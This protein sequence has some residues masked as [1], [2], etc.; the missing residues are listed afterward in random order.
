MTKKIITEPSRD[1]PVVGNFDVVVAGGGPAGVAAAVAAARAGARTALLEAQGCLGG[2]WTS[3][4]MPWAIDY[5]DKPG[6]MAEIDSCLRSKQVPVSGAP[7][8]SAYDLEQAK[9]RLE[10]LCLQA[11]VHLRLHTRVCSALLENRDI[12]AVATE[13]KSGREAWGGR[14]FIDSTGDGELAKH[15]GCGF[16]YGRPDIPG[17]AQPMSLVGLLGGL[18][19]AE[20]KEYVNHFSDSGWANP[21]DALCRILRDNGGSPSYTK[22]TLF[23]VYDDLF[24]LMA[25]H[26][27]GLG[28]IDAEALTRATI[29][30]R[31]EV[32]QLIEALR[33]HGGPW[34]NTLLIAT[35][36]HIGIR[37]GRRVHG[38]FTL[39]RE[40]LE[41]GARFDDA[42][43][44]VNFCVD[45][46]STKAGCPG[47]LGNG[48]VQ[49]RPYDIPMR[50]L[51]ARDV[52][53]LLLA[54]RCISGDF[55]AHASYRVTGNAV[56]MGEAAGRVG[57]QAALRKV[58]PARLDCRES[59]QQ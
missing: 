8:D 34:Q 36:A 52:D 59:L 24:L 2:I 53:N 57:A 45:I 41:N 25:T 22:P 18:K 50:S 33:R 1:L 30:G 51:I 20:I 14:I 21:K 16:E 23:H 11:G 48:G 6:L 43:C 17:E 39:T 31:E 47:G 54:G 26:Q 19:L 40:D 32:W 38:L 29:E 3:G 4:L 5:R 10:Q 49:A 42:V 35:P 56:P 15:A 58:S 28:G 37:E 55:F 7:A 12:T 44:R 13:S 46:H 9:Y 27:H